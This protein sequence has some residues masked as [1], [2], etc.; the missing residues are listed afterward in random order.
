MNKFGL[1]T[2]L[3]QRKSGIKRKGI[4]R[5][6]TFNRKQIIIPKPIMPIIVTETEFQKFRGKLHKQFKNLAD[7]AMELLDALCSNNKTASVVQLSL[8]PLFRRGY[9]ALF[10]AIGALSFREVSK[11]ENGEG[12][13]SQPQEREELP[14]LELIAEVVPKP[15]QRA[16][17]LL[18]LDCTSVERQYAKTLADRGM[19]YQPTQIKGNKP[20]TIGHSYSMLAVIPERKEGDAPWTIP[21][22]ISRVST[23]SNSNQKGIEQLKA[24]LSN[25]KLAWSKELCVSVVDSAYGNK[26]FLSPLQE[27][28]NLVTVARSRSSRVFYQSPVISETPMGKGHP[29][30]YGA[31]FAIKEPD[32]WHEPIAVL[33]L[34]YKN[35]SGRIVNVTITAWA[36]MLM[37]GGKATPT[38]KFPFTL[39]RIESFD[40]AGQSLFKP[41]WLI[42]IGERRGELS[43]LQAYQSYRQRF[44]LE[45]TFRFGKQNLLLNTF[46]TSDVEHEQQWVKFVMLAY[47]QLWAAHSLA[48]SLPRPWEKHLISVPSARISPSKVQQDWFRI[49]SQLGSPAVSPQPRGYSSGR[50]SGEIQSP[51]PRLPVIKKRTSP[52][53][54]PKIPA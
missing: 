38:H 13:D 10:K 39:L 43:P 14:L 25:P 28:Q 17:Y 4:M 12:E 47:V 40:D 11:V 34:S 35:R 2:R 20:I 21:L 26:Q 32:T 7:S 44:D 33:Q 53:S 23:E 9:S 22:D 16:F 54:V 48:V 51:R 29:T 36:N 41:M 46:A 52:A 3:K 42:V 19:V 1:W 6:S 27:H 18:G 15:E 31:R 8:N 24:V 5:V 30:W 45:H 37:R 49:I 50:K